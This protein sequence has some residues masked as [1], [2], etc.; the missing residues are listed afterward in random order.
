MSIKTLDTHTHPSPPFET[1]INKAHK[2]F[3]PTERASAPNPVENHWA[4][5]RPDTLLVKVPPLAYK[6]WICPSDSTRPG[7]ASHKFPPQ[8]Q[9]PPEKKIMFQWVAASKEKC[10]CMLTCS[11]LFWH[12]LRLY[13]KTGAHMQ[14]MF[15][16][17]WTCL[18]NCIS[19]YLP[20][21]GIKNK[22]K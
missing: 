8:E 3:P 11:W 16:F 7:S 2:S 20:H 9:R 13:L 17:L 22:M 21:E 14:T 19:V 10:V 1:M 12:V 4:S 5:D 6:S 15:N 18:A